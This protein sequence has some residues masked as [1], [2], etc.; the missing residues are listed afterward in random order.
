[1]VSWCPLSAKSALL[2][3]ETAL[4]SVAAALSVAEVCG[5]VPELLR[6][7]V[8]THTHPFC[9]TLAL[10]R[11]GYQTGEQDLI[12]NGFGVFSSLDRVGP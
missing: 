3:T 1:M 9:D 6:G 11:S 5:A 10:L 8:A 12:S 2:G 4:G 7:A